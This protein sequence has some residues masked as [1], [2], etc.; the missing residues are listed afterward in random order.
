MVATVL[1]PRSSVLTAQPQL[2][3]AI[4][5]AFSVHE[6]ARCVQGSWLAAIACSSAIRSANAE[7]RH[8]HSQA[9]DSSESSIA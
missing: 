8:V 5:S 9:V 4:A 7:M 3:P 2:M 1:R 6:P